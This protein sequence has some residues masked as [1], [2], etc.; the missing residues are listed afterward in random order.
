MPIIDGGRRLS[1]ISPHGRTK[2]VHMRQTPE[3]VKAGS[4]VYTTKHLNLRV[5]DGRGN[6][7]QT[8]VKG[9]KIPATLKNLHT[10]QECFG[11]NVSE[12]VFVAL[13]L[14]AHAIREGR[15]KVAL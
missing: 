5:S 14:T 9:R 7:M 13:Q 11:L 10:I 3:S 8:A 1:V 12:S 15:I 2:I 4:R 6:F